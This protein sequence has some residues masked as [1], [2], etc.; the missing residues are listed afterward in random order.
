MTTPTTGSTADVELDAL[1]ASVTADLPSYLADLERLV[2]IDCGSY[3]PE[4]VRE[5]GRWTAG[6]LEDLGAH[7]DVRPDPTGRFAE[8]VAI[9]V[10]RTR[11]LRWVL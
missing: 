5:V 2:N 8:T 11:R 3:T 4:G 7:I 6:F 10:K 1:R 9:T